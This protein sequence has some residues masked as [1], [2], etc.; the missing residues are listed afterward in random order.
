[1]IGKLLRLVVTLVGYVSTATVI[2]VAVGLAYLWQT[3]RLN[4]EKVFRMTAVFY[5]VDLDRIAEAQRKPTQEAPPEEPSLTE[6]FRHQQVLDRNYEFK[7]LALQRNRQEYDFQRQ[8]LKE[9]IDRRDRMAQ[10]FLN[11]VRQQREQATLENVSTV[12]A[13][14]EQLRAPQ[15]KELLRMTIDEDM[16]DAILLMS[17]MADSKLRK[18]LNEFQ[19]PEELKEL[20]D[21]HRRILETGAEVS[22]LEQALNE[23]GA[24]GAAN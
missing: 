10:D 11:Q 15:A 19:T 16:D 3:D 21:I 23:L 17:R 18:I 12:V 5:D 9:T 2:A 22:E 1:M 4:D 13:H 6:L 20:H 7:M 8:R 24:G 14:L